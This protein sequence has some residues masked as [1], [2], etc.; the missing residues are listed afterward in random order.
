MKRPLSMAIASCLAF[1][2]PVC[3]HETVKVNAL[4]LYDRI[5]APPPDAAAAHVRL[6][7][8]PESARRRCDVAKFYRAIDGELADL[9]RRIDEAQASL[10][11][12]AAPAAPNVDPAALQKQIE[13]MTPE[14]AMQFAMQFSR[15]MTGAQAA[16]PESA[17][18]R[19]AIAEAQK[20]NSRSSD[21]LL[22]PDETAKR[23][24]RIDL[25]RR[26][27]LDEL[28][29]WREA[30]YRKL[31]EVNLGAVVG[32]VKDPK[33][34][35]ALGL[36]AADRRIAAENEYLAALHTLWPQELEK[37]K[38]IHRPLQRALIAADYG[39]TAAGITSRQ[40]LT[41]GQASIANAAAFLLHRSREAS[42]NAGLAWLERL[43]LENKKP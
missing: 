4:E 43:D 14:Q 9:K 40:I 41:H 25:Q 1:A 37:R 22:H 16:P 34:V 30:E 32:I 17:E 31:P 19:A 2:A 27:R 33:A 10:D 35:H 20:V 26:R 11:Q 38:A 8:R 36:Q 12:P 15:Q 3:G 24:A 29:Q 39:E 6:D 5:P 42:E 7:C 28:Q 18:V 21:D 13:K 23:L